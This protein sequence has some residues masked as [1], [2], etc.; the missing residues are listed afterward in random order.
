[1]DTA[2]KPGLLAAAFVGRAP[3]IAHHRPAI[4]SRFGLMHDDDGGGAL[5]G[6]FLILV[7]PAAVIGHR[8]A[9]EE[10]GI[11]LGG[12]IAGIVDQHDTVFPLTSMPA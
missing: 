6:G 10:F 2:L 1:M 8:L 3:G 12:F 11:G 7:G 5:A 9:L 4:G